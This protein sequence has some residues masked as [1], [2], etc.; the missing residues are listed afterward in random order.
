MN[1]LWLLACFLGSATPRAA[2]EGRSPGTAAS[3]PGVVLEQSAAPSVFARTQVLM[4]LGSILLANNDAPGAAEA[5]GQAAAALKAES[6]ESLDWAAAMDGLGLA[7]HAQGQLDPAAKAWESALAARQRLAPGSLAYAH[8]LNL[9][10]QIARL[11]NDFSRAEALH[12]QALEIASRLDPGGAEMAESVYRMGVVALYRGDF[13]RAESQCARALA[14][15][16]TL[17]P[18]S[19]E[20]AEVLICLEEG[21][22]SRGHFDT[23]MERLQRARRIVSRIAPG[24]RNEARV[25]FGMGLIA[26]GR[27]DLPAATD[28]YTQALAMFLRLAPESP[29]ASAAMSNLGAILHKRGDLEQAEDYYRRSLVIKEKREPRS[30]NTGAT[31]ANLGDLYRVRGELERAETT[32][33][34]ALEILMATAPKHPGIAGVYGYLAAVAKDRGDLGLAERRARETIRFLA[35]TAPDSLLLT[36]GL[37]TAAALAADRG[38][39][40]AARR[41][42][43]RM[44]TI[45]THAS[46]GSLYEAAALQGLG[47]LD[48][49]Q[50]R[51][52]RAQERYQRVLEIRQH[53]APGSADE[54]KALASLARLA[55]KRGQDD[56]AIRTFQRAVDVLD[57]QILTL[58]GS[59]ENK[60]DVR[61]SM[62]NT[63]RSLIALLVRRGRGEE[64]FAVLERSRGRSFL[65]LLAERDLLFPR[66]LPEELERTR[67]A[68]VGEYDRVEQQLAALDP[69][70]ETAKIEEL[71]RQLRA[72]RDRYVTWVEGLR[73]ASPRLAALE[74]PVP[75]SSAAAQEVLDPGTVML[76]YSLGAERS[77]LFILRRDQ[78]LV[79]KTL[80]RTAGQLR[81]EVKLFRDLL[82]EARPGSRLGTSR[83]ASLRTLAR[84]LYGELI[85]PA[86]PYVALSE[87]ILFI[88]DGALHTLPWGALAGRE[89]YLVEWKP[90]H[91]ALSATVY[92]E[93]R[94]SRRG[95]PQATEV[96]LAAF[97]DPA[98]PPGLIAGDAESIA[99]PRVRAGAERGFRFTPLPAS[100]D[101]VLG[102]AR[103]YPASHRAYLREEATE[104][105][106]KAISGKVR[107]LHFATHVTM[108]EHLPFNSAVV[109]S[110]PE[111]FAEGKENGLLQTWEIFDQLRLDADLVT[112]SGCDSALGRELAGE[113]LIGLT[114]AFQY[115]GARSVLAS[116]W[117]VGDNTTGELMIRFY[118]HLR[119]GQPKDEALR[120]AQRELV[121]TLTPYQ[122]AAFQLYGDWR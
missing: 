109:L 69:G 29:D 112:L 48:A 40:A 121:P 22:Y 17:A 43:E 120:Q 10:G 4:D 2:E 116:L 41:D 64:A 26:Q 95:L 31:L 106:A 98:I 75:L 46:P 108:D 66:D 16:E 85:A 119:E 60:A 49:R 68:I 70:K 114:R 117:K 47:D 111:H 79:V 27:D 86:A 9:M 36:G 73:Q 83:A 62:A 72:L 34:R 100:R 51:F 30:F 12:Q 8:S 88:P 59:E 104:E 53:L 110:I 14:L 91:L 54:A 13:D 67:R 52:T 58:G 45:A 39:L 115:A 61:A 35:K 42:L 99:D 122:W 19:R 37:E 63:Y 84:S 78:P 92:A 107:Y 33:Q 38:D 28:F 90:F 24:S 87:R 82:A 7:F 89:R 65:N 56:L 77:Y 11:R 32:L 93:L 5:Y 113:G 105:S 74:Y 57:Q 71:S 21:D 3:P 44:L 1:V 15:F 103:L 102:I 55:E 80:A 20:V 6:G 76:S 81:R 96:D 118:R 25:L 97:G 18:D 101:E 94:R 23:A 50:G